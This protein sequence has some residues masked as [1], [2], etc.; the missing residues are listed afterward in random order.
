MVRLAELLAVMLEENSVTKG[1]H[2]EFTC[3][4]V[5]VRSRTFGFLRVTYLGF[6]SQLYHVTV[7][8]IFQISFFKLIDHRAPLSLCKVT[9][10]WCWSSGLIC[11]RRVT[12]HKPTSWG[13]QGEATL[14]GSRPG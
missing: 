9:A 10:E 5:F 8:S 11:H 1:N 12:I 14:G 4:K 3:I 2:F 6:S 13:S 7:T